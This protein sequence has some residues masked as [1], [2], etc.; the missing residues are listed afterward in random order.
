MRKARRK[1]LKAAPSW[2][3]LKA[4]P[5]LGGF[6]SE[7][8]SGQTA[9]VEVTVNTANV[10]N[11]VNPLVL[12][13]NLDWPHSAQGFYV[14]GTQNV[15]PGFLELAD[16]LSPT[17]LR[18]P[19]G[20]NSDFYD[21]RAG[22]GPLSQRRTS[23][24][25]EGN[26]ERVTMGTDEFL[27]FCKRWR[28]EPLITVNL[29]T[30]KPQ[31]A[32]DWVRYVNKRTSDLP[33]V[34]YW[35]IGNEP[36]LEA[37]FPEA[38]VTPQDYVQR[39]TAFIAAMRAVDPTIQTGLVLRSDT[40]GG[41]EAT[42]Y[43]GYNDIVLSGVTQPY[44]FAALH[45]SYFPV[46]FEKKETQEQMFLATM[47]GSRT[48]NEDLEATRAQLRRYQP[49]RSIRIA[50]TEYNTLYSM[51]ILKD[52]SAVFTST[53]DRYIESMASAL[54]CADLLRVFSQT[55]DLLMANYWSLVGNWWY[56]AISH[57]G[58]PRPQFHVLEAY[59]ELVY[60]RLIETTVAGPTMTTPRCGFVPPYT[61]VQ[62]VAAHSVLGADM[63]RTAIINKH[64]S[65]SATITLKTP[66]VDRARIMI[67]H[68]A[69]RSLLRT[70]C[71]MDRTADRH[72]RRARRIRP[73]ETFVRIGEDRSGRLGQTKTDRGSSKARESG[74]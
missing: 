29:A 1:L 9:A 57:D 46:T 34:K 51:D 12:D 24:T 49:N 16:R 41:V 69:Q 40:L 14:E 21:W 38:K 70:T 15:T 43:R 42:P 58:K 72:P 32:A 20:T 44:Q 61:G 6:I 26:L 63:M 65:N 5:L 28:S 8:A 73:A 45:S 64:P 52:P 39:A 62:Q 35:E 17:A 67:P 55:D 10:L 19:G 13:N 53:T 47:A 25:L 31:D 18:Y 30:G 37:Y 4:L 71:L 60:G 22:V 59:R 27:A 74:S 23:K 11:A 48:L 3:A 68:A 56:G 36:Y 50:F 33:K 2:A 7:T 54:Y 66:G